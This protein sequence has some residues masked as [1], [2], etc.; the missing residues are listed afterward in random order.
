M[1]AETSSTPKVAASRSRTVTRRSRS[2]GVPAGLKVRRASRR[3]VLWP[4]SWYVEQRPAQVP[5]VERRNDDADGGQPRHGDH[6]HDERK[7]DDRDD[8]G[9]GQAAANREARARA[10]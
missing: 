1:N 6:A 10:R 2:V 5:R 4:R 3:R 7:H 8:D 9:L